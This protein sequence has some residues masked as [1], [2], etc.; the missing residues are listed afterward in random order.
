[1][2][3]DSSISHGV[4]ER[5]AYNSLPGAMTKDLWARVYLQQP[6]ELAAIPTSPHVWVSDGDEALVYSLGDNYFCCTANYNQGWPR[7]IQHMLHMS[8]D[9]GIAI[10]KLGPVSASIPA[11]GGL[12][13]NVSG[14]FPFDDD[15]TIVLHG[16]P[17][18]PVSMPVYVRIP[19]WATAATLSINGAAPV[20]VGRYNGTM[21]RVPLQGLLGMARVNPI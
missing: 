6:N 3:Q 1:M 2:L 21:L 12:T 20:S 4:Q 13:V 18:G 9:G 16:L 17:A 19:A 7:H 8:P 15:V 11:L 10:S 14:D 5:I